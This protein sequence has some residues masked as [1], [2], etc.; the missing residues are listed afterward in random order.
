[1][2]SRCIVLGLAALLAGAGCS[3]NE[4]APVADANDCCQCAGVWSDPPTHPQSY[5]IAPDCQDA[6]P[7]AEECT[8]LCKSLGHPRG[9]LAAG[10]CG[11]APAGSGSICQ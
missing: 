5:A 10:R 2:R 9:G 11:P 4:P 3:R 6:A 8:A 1:V 7:G